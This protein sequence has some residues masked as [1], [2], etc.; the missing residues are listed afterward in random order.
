[1]WAMKVCVEDE[2]VSGAS[3]RMAVLPGTSEGDL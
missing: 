2:W 3:E 1:M